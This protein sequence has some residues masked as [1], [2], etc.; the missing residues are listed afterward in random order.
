MS[1]KLVSL[2]LVCMLLLSVVLTGCSTNEVEMYQSFKKMADLSYGG[3]VE[4]TGEIEMNLGSLKSLLGKEDALAEKVLTAIESNK[5]TYVAKMDVTK[6]IADTQY[7]LENK[8]TGTKT[9]FIH[10]IRANEAYYVDVDSFIGV[11]KQYVEGS[12]LKE[13]NA[14]DARGKWLK[15]TDAEYKDLVFGAAGLPKTN[16]AYSNTSVK[17]S[18]SKKMIDL[19]TRLYD[20]LF[21]AYDKMGSNTVQK[22]DNT[23]TFKLDSD[24]AYPFIEQTA[25]FTLDHVEPI[26]A[27]MANFFTTL[28]DEEIKMM[29][30]TR[31]D[32]DQAAKAMK[33]SIKKSDIDNARKQLASVTP[34][35]KEMFKSMYKGSQI[36]YAVT[37]KDKDTFNNAFDFTIKLQSPT[38]SDTVSFVI[39]GKDE[40]KRLESVAITAPD[41]QIITMADVKAITPDTLTFYAKSSYALNKDLVSSYGE[42]KV[43]VK[44]GRSYV[45][46]NLVANSFGYQSLTNATDK[47]VTFTKG[48]VKA[49]MGTLTDKGEV[50]V[51]AVDLEKIGVEV[52]YEAKTQVLTL[53]HHKVK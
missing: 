13:L 34:E 47:T 32:A 50:F 16:P 33:E 31:S 3:P 30:L 8:A 53:V 42:T 37:S 41:T 9:L 40:I 44:E 20:G 10:M 17:L 24:T 5:L 21:K 25:F 7:F 51:K 15:L 36:L 28:S 19:Y 4:T 45:P 27:I 35:M 46:V 18:D 2:L 23:Y 39:K 11:I 26:T 12:D 49:T 6:D 14:L 29:G 38:S 1:K 22:S 52:K 48:D 43:M